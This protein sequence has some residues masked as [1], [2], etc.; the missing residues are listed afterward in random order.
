MEEWGKVK[1]KP[2]RQI[3]AYSH[4]FRHIQTYSGII[5]AYSEPCVN[6]AYSE[7]Q[8]I[9]NHGIFQTRGTFRTL[10]YPKLWYIKNQRLIQNPGLVRTLGYSE[11]CQTSTM[12]R[13]EKHLTAIIMSRITIDEI[14]MIFNAGLIFTLEVFILCKE[15]C[16]PRTRSRGQ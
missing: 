6:L 10:A 7:L 13:F 4:I 11:P 2:L 5:Q 12:E 9:Q 8:Y 16:V 15:V 14:N 3:Q 1:Q